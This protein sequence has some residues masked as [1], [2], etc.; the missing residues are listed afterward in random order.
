MTAGGGNLD[1]RDRVMQRAG[2]VIT[3]VALMGLAVFERRW[4]TPPA[5]SNHDPQTGFGRLAE[6]P[7]NLEGWVGQDDR[8]DPRAVELAEISGSW[9][10]HYRQTKS[11]VVVHVLIVGG[12]PGPI[13]L[14]PPDVCYRGLGFEPSGSARANERI[15]ELNPT[16]MFRVVDLERDDPVN[17]RRLRI[18]WAWSSQGVWNVPRSP[19]IAYALEPWLYK[20]YA[21]RELSS[22]DPEFSDEPCLEILR[23]LLPKIHEALFVRSA[24]QAASAGS[25]FNHDG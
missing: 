20:I 10:R 1:A 8:L 16:S 15:V 17:P 9:Y 3:L 12:R 4:S 22:T 6:L 5:G 11:G 2:L 21:H 19:R 24:A 14:H 18:Y 7:L 13:A 23:L 25:L